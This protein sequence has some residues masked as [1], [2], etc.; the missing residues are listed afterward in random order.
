MSYSRFGPYVSVAEKREKAAREV[1]KLQKQG[2]EVKPVV[3]TGKSLAE[4][5]WGKAWCRHLDSY[6]DYDNRLARGR[7]YVRAGAVCH[8]EIEP[9]CVRALV[10]GSELY[11]VQV[12]IKPLPQSH[13]KTLKTRCQGQIGDI[14]EILQG[15]L[16]KDILSQMCAVQGGLFP[17]AKDIK[18]SCSCPDWASMCK[19]VAA[20]LYGVGKR[21]DTEPEL[22]FLLRQVDATELL[23]TEALLAAVQTAHKPPKQAEDSLQ[24]DDLGALFGIE[25]DRGEEEPKVVVPPKKNRRRASPC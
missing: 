25:L 18:F 4:T 12:N 23:T 7:S 11:E 6:A 2:H 17:G 1:G 19:H 8:L 9:G 3:L 14:L 5:F 10:S 13:W 20:T 16:P 15:K 21:L 22:L 24:V